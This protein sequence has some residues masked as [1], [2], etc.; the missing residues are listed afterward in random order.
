MLECAAKT[1]L[2]SGAPH[3][4]ADSG[5]RRGVR[6]VS[7]ARF[8]PVCVFMSVTSALGLKSMRLKI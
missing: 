7:G 3:K 1:D 4:K 2:H 8:A 6:A 5:Q